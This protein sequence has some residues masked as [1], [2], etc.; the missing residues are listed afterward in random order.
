[1]PRRLTR[2]ALLLIASRL[3]AQF[4][5]GQIAG[6]VKDPS[7][8]VVAQATVTVRNENTGEQR[9]TRTDESGYYVFPNLVVGT[10]TVTTEHAGFKKSV[11]TGITLSSA[12]S[13]Q[14]RPPADCRIR[15]RNRGGEG[16]GR[17]GPG[18]ICRGRPHD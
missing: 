4:D 12:D 9:Q 5:S 18:R 6:F 15:I 13:H 16:D 14:H 8:A 7:E 11:Q 2:T 10:Y 17:P 1:M 3:F